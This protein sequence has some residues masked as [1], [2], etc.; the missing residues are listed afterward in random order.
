MNNYYSLHLGLGVGVT[1]WSLV[2]VVDVCLVILLCYFIKIDYFLYK[3]VYF[4][5]SCYY[6]SINGTL[7][8]FNGR[9]VFGRVLVQMHVLLCYV[10][11]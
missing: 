3:V 4:I 10:V 6:H 11:V 7:F 8:M 5:Y 1:V 9:P 2:F